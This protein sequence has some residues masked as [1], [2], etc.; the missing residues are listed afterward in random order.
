MNNPYL[1]LDKFF[2]KEN[3]YLQFRKQN[4]NDIYFNYVAKENELKKQ[5]TPASRY[6]SDDVTDK[7]GNEYKHSYNMIPYSL[8]DKGY[9]DY[10]SKYNC[11]NRYQID[12]NDYDNKY[13]RKNA[14]V[15]KNNERSN[16]VQEKYIE[17][18]IRKEYKKYIVD[19]DNIN[20][21][22]HCAYNA[23]NRRSRNKSESNIGIY[24]YQNPMI[25]SFK[26]VAEN[27]LI[28]VNPCKNTFTLIYIYA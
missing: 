19:K 4:Q 28:Q 24:K 26:Q 21:C 3:S 22:N 27:N 1:S 18:D 7:I 2:N 11:Y 5:F 17:T 9:K 23:Y 15:E 6:N 25:M 10:K 20:K 13:R 16:N 12:F 8:I 14:V